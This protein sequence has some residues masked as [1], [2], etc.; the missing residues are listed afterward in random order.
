[1]DRY[2]A[3]LNERWKSLPT[4]KQHR[5]TLYIFVV[6]LLLTAAVIF[7]VWYDTSRSGNEMIIE[8]MENPVLKNKVPAR[9]QEPSINK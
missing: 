5:Y 2:F 3:K 8:H 9:L 6:Y 4:E 7:K 1:M